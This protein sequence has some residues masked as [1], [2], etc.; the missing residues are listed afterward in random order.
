M[1]SKNKFSI[2]IDYKYKTVK[3]FIDNVDIG[4]IGID[5]FY[6]IFFKLQANNIIIINNIEPFKFD[7]NESFYLS[8]KDIY[9][10]Q[11]K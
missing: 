5:S 9:I 4:E 11:N 6:D 3:K 2:K 8:I 7:I 10:E 1:L